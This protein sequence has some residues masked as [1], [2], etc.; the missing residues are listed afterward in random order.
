MT[1]TAADRDTFQQRL[2]RWGPAVG[3]VS[4]LTALFFVSRLAYLLNTDAGGWLLFFGI[5]L[6]LLTPVP[7]RWSPGRLMLHGGVALS[8]GLMLWKVDRQA[9]WQASCV[10]YSSDGPVDIGTGA[11]YLRPTSIP[12]QLQVHAVNARR[13]DEG[14]RV[15]DWDDKVWL[16]FDPSSA[17]VLEA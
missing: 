9:T 16:S 10:M 14:S 2:Q 11:R 1:R 15:A 4:A 12:S 8:L 7:T 13:G 3:A 17:I 5:M 6:V